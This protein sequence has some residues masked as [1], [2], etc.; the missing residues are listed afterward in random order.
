MTNIFKD[1]KLL[2]TINDADEYEKFIKYCEST[3][4]KSEEYKIWLNSIDRSTCAATN[5]TNDVIDIEVHHYDDN[6]YII[7][8]EVINAFIDNNLKF[9]TWI[10]CQILSEIHLNDC[11][12]YIPLMHCIH[13]MIHKNSIMVEEKYPDTLKHVHYGDI[14]KRK[15]IIQKYINFYKDKDVL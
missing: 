6:L 12:T 2:F 13:K 8:S 11:V 4:R 9:N 14:E 10:I 5:L 3:F 15:E 7:C 1:K